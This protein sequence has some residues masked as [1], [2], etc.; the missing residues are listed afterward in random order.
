MENSDRKL[1]V[2]LVVAALAGLCG[3]F[4][5]TLA[6]YLWAFL[7]EES[8]A[9][10]MVAGAVSGIVAAPLW[11]L[12]VARSLGR[13]RAAG[14]AVDRKLLAKVG[15]GWGIVAGMASTL[16]VHAA[17]FSTTGFANWVRFGTLLAIGEAFGIVAGTAVGGL[18]AGILWMASRPAFGEGHDA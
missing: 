16:V 9:T 6:G 2:V 10:G 13:R 8:G 4:F 3:G 11:Y 1:L 5:G 15:A 7:R 14:V 17:I 18:G 12:A